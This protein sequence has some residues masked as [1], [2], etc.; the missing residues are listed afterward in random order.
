MTAYAVSEPF[1]NSRHICDFESFVQMIA[2]VT[3]EVIN[4]VKSPLKLL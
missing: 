2:F 1:T 3:S 4:F